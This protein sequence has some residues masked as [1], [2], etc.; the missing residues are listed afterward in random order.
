MC[1]NWFLL[2]LLNVRAIYAGLSG[3]LWL[4]QHESKDLVD[5]FINDLN[6]EVKLFGINARVNKKV[7]G[8]PVQSL[9]RTE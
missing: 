5:F 7:P 3:T 9:W 8:V 4:W 2:V 6:D 1:G